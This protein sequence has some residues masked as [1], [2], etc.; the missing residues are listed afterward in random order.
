MGERDRAA[1]ARARILL[2][3]VGLARAEEG[4]GRRARLLAFLEAPRLLHRLAAELR[5]HQL[6]ELKLLLGGEREQLVSRLLRLQRTFRALASRD[7]LGER[8]SVA[9]DVL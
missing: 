1:S 3:R 8:R 5:R 7:D 4:L 2:G 6:L 9:A